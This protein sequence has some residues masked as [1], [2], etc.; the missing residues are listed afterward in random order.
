[1]TYALNTETRLNILYSIYTRL[2]AIIAYIGNVW[3]AAWV[4]SVYCFEWVC[5][6]CTL[7]G[8][9]RD[10]YG[11]HLYNPTLNDIFDSLWWECVCCAPCCVLC[12]NLLFPFAS[13]H[14]GNFYVVGIN[15][16]EMTRNP[17]EPR[18][19]QT[20]SCVYLLIIIIRSRWRFW[21]S[22]S[23]SLVLPMII[24]RMRRRLCVCV[25]ACMACIQIYSDSI[26]LSLRMN[27]NNIEIAL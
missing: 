2:R 5:G 11:I 19:R 4:C 27:N 22:F 21:L 10:A 9:E 6:T 20:A 18:E 23:L 17:Y 12:R 24:F 15:N 26:S 13:R 25:Y 1:M 3:S 14:S 7:F 16:T 8:C